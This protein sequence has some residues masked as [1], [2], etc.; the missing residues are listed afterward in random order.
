MCRGYARH[1]VRAHHHV[2]AEDKA[3]TADNELLLRI[4]HYEL[5]ARRRHRVVTVDVTVLAG[6]AACR[7]ECNLA[8]ASNLA[9]GV[10]SVVGVNDIYGVATLVGGA[11]EFVIGKFVLDE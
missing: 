3:V 4:P 1:T 7:A 11:Q 2:G 8:Q 9:H 5:A 6:T 10:G